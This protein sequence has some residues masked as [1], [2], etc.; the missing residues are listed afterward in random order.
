MA[1]ALLAALVPATGSAGSLDDLMNVLAGV[2]ARRAR[3]VE[4]RSIGVLDQP[5]VTEGTFAFDAPD[6]L[7]RQDL[8][9]APAL[10][11][12]DGDRLEIVIDG[13]ERTLS[14]DQE[15]VVQALVAPF[16]AVFAGDLGMLEESFDV[17][18]AD[19]GGG[20]KLTLKPKTGS[21]ARRFLEVVT[22]SGAG[23]HVE[24]IETR[25]RGGDRSVMRLEPVTAPGGGDG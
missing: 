24:R 8:T 25:E 13:E 21:P 6:R 3:F 22:V 4:E 20:W 10:Y 12:L 11:T 18:Y 2:E 1:A 17:A 15:P 7:T 5:L 19:D 14:L 16:R 9:P 23:E